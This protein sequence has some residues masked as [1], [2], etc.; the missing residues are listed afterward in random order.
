M[1]RI[2]PMSIKEIER[3]EILI[4]VGQK[5]L[6][7]TQAADILG[8]TPRQVRRLMRKFEEY[9]P[10]GL[11]SR[12]RGRPGNHRLPAGAKELA[13]AIIQEEY[14]D[15]GPTLAH[16]KIKE[17]HKIKISLWSV[18]QIMICNGLWRD[19]K[20]KKKRIYQLRERRPREGEL[21]QI[22]GSPH[23]WFEGRGPKCS[24]AL[25]MLREK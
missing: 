4:R 21:I 1:E 12:K 17:R 18:R 3:T 22:D 16:E 24:I 8:I 19:K 6:I 11:V 15:F 23:H 5:S 9:G 20:T 10:T 13:L 14:P 25:M 7:Q 2:I